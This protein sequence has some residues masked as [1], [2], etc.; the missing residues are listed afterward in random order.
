V[1]KGSSAYKEITGAERGQEVFPGKIWSVDEIDEDVKALDMP[2]INIQALISQIQH[3]EA[4]LQQ[5]IGGEGALGSSKRQTASEIH[6]LT[7]KSNAP[8]SVRLSLFA[9]TFLDPMLDLV[10]ATVQQYELRDQ[11]I[12]IQDSQG[13]PHRVTIT[14]EELST[15]KYSV[16]SALSRDDTQRIAYTQTLERVLPTLAQLQPMAEAENHRIRLVPIVKDFLRRLRVPRVDQTVEPIPPQ[17]LKRMQQQVIAQQQGGANPPQSTP[18]PQQQ[19]MMPQ[20]QMEMGQQMSPSA[21]T[22]QAGGPMGTG[23]D[24]DMVSQLLQEFAA[25]TEGRSYQG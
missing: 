12:V 7:E 3:L 22:G 9:D 14:N 18:Q 11:A 21:P 2:Q 15:G 25:Q 16:M 5:R 1:R 13:N 23:T 4:Q 24:A 8:L 6:Y 20:T 17:E 19:E 10:L